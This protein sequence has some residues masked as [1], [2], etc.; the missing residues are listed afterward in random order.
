MS[1]VYV[2]IGTNDG[3][4]NF[5]LKVLKAL[6]D[7]IILV[8][9][10]PELTGVIKRNY[11]KVKGVNVVNKAIYPEDDKEVELY[12]PS[13]NGV[14][15]RRAD[16]G[17]VYSHQHFSLVPM[18]DWGSKEDMV[19]IKAQT[20]TFS[21]LCE[22]F[23]IKEI[24][25]L[26]IDTEG[27]DVEII[28]MIDFEKVKIKQIRYEKW[29]FDSEKF[30]KYNKNYESLGFNGMELIKK[31]LE[32]HGYSLQEVNDSDGCDFVATLMNE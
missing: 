28:K 13:K 6:P 4:D 17:I 14:M 22:Q 18:N 20:I 11:N 16:N 1:K 25:Y 2:Q 7:K 31:K 21:S 9:P 10:N 24:E 8:E 30:T 27:F 12:F 29:L 5:R 26:Q 19:K 32:S 15:G 3:K 23:D